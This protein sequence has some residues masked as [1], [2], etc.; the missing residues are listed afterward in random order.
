MKLKKI[1]ATL[2]L[3]TTLTLFVHIGFTTYAFLMFFYNERMSAE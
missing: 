1:N 2:S 3:L